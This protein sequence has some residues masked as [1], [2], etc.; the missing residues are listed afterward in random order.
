MRAVIGGFLRAFW[1][2]IVAGIVV[3]AL[4]LGTSFQWGKDAKEQEIARRPTPTA[5][6]VVQTV[7]VP[8]TVVVMAA[9]PA[10]ATPTRILPTPTP[11]SLLTLAPTA[12]PAAPR[13][14]PGK[15]PPPAPS[16]AE[17]Y[18]IF[19]GDDP[20]KLPGVRLTGFN[21]T[22]LYETSEVRLV[23]IT[24]CAKAAVME[25][26]VWLQ[27]QAGPKKGEWFKAEDKTFSLKIS[28][29]QDVDLQ[30]Y[31]FPEIKDKVSGKVLVPAK[32]V[33]YS[34]HGQRFWVPDGTCVV[35]WQHDTSSMTRDK[36]WKVEFCH[37]NVGDP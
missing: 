34:D 12:V 25:F 31:L 23:P 33:E 14:T 37:P 26:E 20:R 3:V 11:T 13:T 36:G 21:Q 1:I 29:N 32:T 16:C 30:L 2:W 8:Q 4:I 19:F 18:L 9:T 22:N 24:G 5:L 7:V 35:L 28:L 27:N 15:T 6:V 10:P 17:P